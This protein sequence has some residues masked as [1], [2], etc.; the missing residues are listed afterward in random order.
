MH[1]LRRSPAHTLRSPWQFESKEALPS[2]TSTATT[3]INRLTD[4]LGMN[5]DKLNVRI[6]LDATKDVMPDEILLEIKIQEPTLRRPGK[7]S[8]SMTFPA[9][10]K[11]NIER[12][13][14]P[15]HR[16][17]LELCEVHDRRGQPQG[18]RHRGARR[19]HEFTFV[20]LRAGRRRM[21]RS[22]RR[23]AGC[24]G[25]TDPTG[26]FR[27]SNPTQKRCSCA[28]GVELLEI[29][30]P[31]VIGIQVGDRPRPGPLFGAPPTSLLFR[32][33]RLVELQPAARRSSPGR[34]TAGYPLWLSPESLLASWK[35]QK[36][37]TTRQWTSTS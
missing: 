15:R 13:N 32:P 34:S 2:W 28:G 30:V 23:Q 35:K 20:P 17:H 37:I 33:W 1:Y 16:R 11:S 14:I 19:R 6:E 27:T 3:P 36:E 29:S 9:T 25:P 7:S 26:N 21:G 12:A 10:A 22:R 4:V 24:Q 8:T 31:I 18:S 5:V